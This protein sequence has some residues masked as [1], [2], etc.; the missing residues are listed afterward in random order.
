MTTSH[1]HMDMRFNSNN[2]RQFIFLVDCW[3]E[4]CWLNLSSDI[5]VGLLSTSK[6]SLRGETFYFIRASPAMIASL[7]TQKVQL[8]SLAIVFHYTPIEHQF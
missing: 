1:S 6:V 4:T 5:S 7:A 2:P 8:T 3:I